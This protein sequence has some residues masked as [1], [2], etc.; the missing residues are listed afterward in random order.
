MTD[1]AQNNETA[2][3]L[4]HNLIKIPAGKNAGDVVGERHDIVLLTEVVKSNPNGDPDTGNM[5]R[6]QPDSMKGLMTDGCQKRK[7]RNFFSLYNPD[8]SLRMEDAGWQEGWRIFIREGAILQEQIEDPDV[9]STAEMKFRTWLMRQIP[10][11]YQQ[12]IVDALAGV[13]P[14]S[15]QDKKV[16]KEI[17]KK[18]LAAWKD[19]KIPKAPRGG[20]DSESENEVP[21]TS[22]ENDVKKGKKRKENPLMAEFDKVLKRSP[23]YRERFLRDALCATYFD[24]RFFGGV[25]STEGPLKGSFYGQ[26]RGPIQFGYAESLDRVYPLDFT[27]T[28]CASASDKDVNQ[29]GEGDGGSESGGNRTMGRKH[30]VDYGIYRSHI[31]FSPAFALKTRFTYYDLDNFL[32]AVQHMYTDDRAAARPGGM[33]VVGLVDFQHSTALGN[34]HAHKLFEMVKVNRAGMGEDG[35]PEKEFPQSIADYCGEA[36]SGAVKEKDQGGLGNELVTAH[37]IIWDIPACPKKS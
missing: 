29:S 27:I 10:G 12:A 8:S 30:V 22:E 1:Q 25:A 15:E 21:S 2:I 36:P 14:Q 11:E 4:H 26:I 33:R 6:L 23:E 13:E 28:R 7:I 24:V 16:Y 20:S 31:F 37:K 34:E 32:F 9:N 35:K 5:P 17:A 18:Y 3:T 19:G